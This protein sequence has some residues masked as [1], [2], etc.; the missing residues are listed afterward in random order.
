MASP[1]KWS[2]IIRYVSAIDDKVKLGEPI[3]SENLL[4]GSREIDLGQLAENGTLE[5]MAFE[6]S[7]IFSISCVTGKDKVKRILGPL[8]SKD[9]PIIR[10]IGLN[11]KSHSGYI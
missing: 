1:T 5:V 9:V 10:C 7:D 8:D 2:R 6:G 4:E 11:Y 3:I